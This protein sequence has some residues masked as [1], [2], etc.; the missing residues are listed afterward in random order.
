MV[1]VPWPR[2]L[3]VLAFG[4]SNTWGFVA[5]PSGGTPARLPDTQR[6]PGVMQAA[7][8]SDVTVLV[9][10]ICGRRT[11]VDAEPGTEQ[12]P[13]SL[14]VVAPSSFNGWA[15][16]EVAGL[17][18]AP[19]DLAIVMLGT[20]DFAIQPARPLA[21]IAQACV[22]VGQA[23][24]RGAAGFTPGRVP[25]VLLLCPPPLGGDGTAPEGMPAWPAFWQASRQLAPALA[26]AA[27]CAGMAFMDGA[28]ATATS[29]ADRIH[30]DAADH[31][32]LGQAVA[33]RVRALLEFAP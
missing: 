25:R 2:P 24:V 7:L 20:N 13:Q 22:R 14:R 32:R 19:L 18:C 17:A 8:G 3:R 29:G 1:D 16:A 33:S 21:D 23:L 11:D 30:L 27:D 9:D 26:Q 6:W 28:A 15:H 31:H 10:A 5:S 4:D 12:D